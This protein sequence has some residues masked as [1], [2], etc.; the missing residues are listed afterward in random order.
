V[1]DNV[2]NVDVFWSKLNHQMLVLKAVHLPPGVQGPFVNFEFGDTEALLIG[3]EMD[4]PDYA[5]LRDYAI[6]LEDSL[7]NIQA[8][9]KVK[10]IGEQKEQIVIESSSAK[11]EQYGISFA[12]V[13][14]VLQSQNAIG[15]A[16]DVKTPDAKIT[17]YS[18]GYYKTEAEIAGQIIGTAK[19]GQVVRL[20]DVARIRRQYQE[21]VSKAMVN[22]RITMLVAV[23]MHEGNNIVEFGKTV[24]Q[25][26][27]ETAKLLPSGVKWTMIVNQPKI[28]DKNVSQFPARVS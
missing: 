2:E 13:M 11:L 18:Q 16:G 19:T 26:L 12:K 24:D 28:V 23:Q 20:K 15:P 8:V 21:P 25:K 5:Q 17:L 27:K 1:N 22:G 4:H 7:K 14:Q 3:I 9:S 6:K 10:R